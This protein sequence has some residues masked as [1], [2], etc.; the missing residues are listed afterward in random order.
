MSDADNRPEIVTELRAKIAELEAREAQRN[1]PSA[2]ITVR[3]P[4][5]LHRRLKEI[6]EQRERSLNQFC[7][8]A[9]VRAVSSHSAE[10]AGISSTPIHPEGAT[11]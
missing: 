4:Q 7:I 11:R 6:A 2:V 1:E 5:R 9:L 10:L 8:D 3:L